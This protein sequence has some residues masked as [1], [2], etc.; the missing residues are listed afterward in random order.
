MERDARIVVTSTPRFAKIVSNKT[1]HNA[2]PQV[3]SDLE[4]NHSRSVARSFLRD[5]A[6]A[7]GLVAQAKE[8]SWHYSM[9]KI[10]EAVKTIAIGLD[11]TC[12]LLCEGGYRETMVG[13]FS[14]YNKVGERIHTI[15]LGAPPEYGKASFYN[16]M[17]VEI[18][19]LKKQ[20]PTARFIGV[21]DGAQDNWGM[22]FAV[23]RVRSC[24]LYL[25]S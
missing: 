12:M 17:D 6:N 24:T 10:Q 1:A 21:A 23:P 8:E 14:L 7:V 5:V 3:Q 16:R 13:N 15:Y 25:W 11:G 20:Y 19:K 18:A 9:P 4:E 22:W 2:T